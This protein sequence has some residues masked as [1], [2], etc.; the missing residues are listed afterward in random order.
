MTRCCA[1]TNDGAAPRPPP[2][3]AC[4]G[5]R[6]RQVSAAFSKLVSVVFI[7]AHPSF[8]KIETRME[9]GRCNL[10]LLKSFKKLIWDGF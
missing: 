9:S 4:E 8:G 2:A 6:R 7:C 5:Q 1:A 3:G 10:Q